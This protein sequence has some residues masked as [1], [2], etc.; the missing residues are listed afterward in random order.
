M[1]SNEGNKAGVVA[2]FGQV[3]EGVRIGVFIHFDDVCQ[4][5]ADTEGENVAVVPFGLVIFWQILYMARED[6]GFF[7]RDLSD[8]EQGIPELG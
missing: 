7:L 2:L 4:A 1:N 3:G 8:H 5:A 6:K